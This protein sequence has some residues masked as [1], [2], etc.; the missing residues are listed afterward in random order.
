MKQQYEIKSIKVPT[1]IQWKVNTLNKVINQI[2]NTREKQ[3]VNIKLQINNI[4][5]VRNSR[6]NYFEII[7]H[8]CNWGATHYICSTLALVTHD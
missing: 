5:K 2:D 7:T 3:K 1:E 6:T 8:N 4:K